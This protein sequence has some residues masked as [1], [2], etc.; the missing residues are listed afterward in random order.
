MSRTR[1]ANTQQG[2]ASTPRQGAAALLLLL[3][4]QVP[5]GNCYLQHN[6][7]RLVSHRK[8]SS[9][10]FSSPNNSNE[11]TFQTQPNAPSSTSIDING[12]QATAS[13]L[14]TT[15]DASKSQLFSAFA[16]LDLNDQYDAVLTGLCANKILDDPK[17]TAADA[18]EALQD[19]LQLLR[20]MNQKKIRASPRSI[21][22]LIDVSNYV[23]VGVNP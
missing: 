3:L 7:V 12:G 1:L 19:P 11:G 22:A 23:C 16:A 21:M 2:P 6:H 9:L 10:S 18:R 17:V 4:L 5:H 8:Q 15:S 20:E 13:S 14:I